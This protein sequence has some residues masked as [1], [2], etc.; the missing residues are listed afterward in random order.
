MH[1]DEYMGKVAIRLVE[2]DFQAYFSKNLSKM[3]ILMAIQKRKTC[4]N[5]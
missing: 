3:V 2:L 4:K 5:E 1:R